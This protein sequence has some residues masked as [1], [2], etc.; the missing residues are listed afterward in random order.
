MNRKGRAAGH[1]FEDAVNGR[2]LRAT[3]SGAGCRRIEHEELTAMTNPSWSFIRGIL[4]ILGLAI[5]AAAT[6]VSAGW[7]PLG[8]PVDPLIILHLDPD[9]PELL[10]ARV[11]HYE[12]QAYL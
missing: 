1:R 4:G 9:R 5:T 6:P 8:G 11:I 2:A 12:Q 7:S 3:V 10:Y